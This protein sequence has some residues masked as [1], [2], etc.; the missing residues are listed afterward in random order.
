MGF[1]TEIVQLTIGKMISHVAGRCHM[2]IP[3]QFCGIRA[4]ALGGHLNTVYHV[5]GV[6][7]F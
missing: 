3:P 7:G 4:A 5:N 2:E 6:L 1:G